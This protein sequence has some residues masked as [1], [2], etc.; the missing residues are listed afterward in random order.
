M[1]NQNNQ[2][3]QDYEIVNNTI[4]FIRDF[5]EPLDN[6]L[7][8]IQQCDEV[9]FVNSFNQPFN[10]LHDHIKKITIENKEYNQPITKLPSQLEEFHFHT[11]FYDFPN[12]EIFEFPKTLKKIGWYCFGCENLEINLKMLPDNL[13]SLTL[14]IEFESEDLHH[15]KN[16]TELTIDI[17]DFDEPLDNLPN[18]IKTLYILSGVYTQPL[19]NLPN[20][21]IELHFNSEYDC[22]PYALDLDNL[23]QSLEKLILPGKYKGNLDNLPSNLK[24]LEISYDYEGTI[25]NLPDSLEVLNWLSIY[26]YKGKITKLPTNLKE[27]IFGHDYE[28]K[29]MKQKIRK[30]LLRNTKIKITDYF[31]VE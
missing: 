11:E 16:L 15:F 5:N 2:P 7:H 25:N 27:V 18:T 22:V 17:E 31:E 20:G 24:Y 29:N 26:E 6:Y 3:N 12:D 30:M 10:N 21:L 1:N 4:R 19:N 13:E 9:W 8:L 28:T 14:G 23:P